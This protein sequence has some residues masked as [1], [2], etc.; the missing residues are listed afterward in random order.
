MKKI[1]G[2]I[3]AIL[4]LMLYGM[5]GAEDTDS[6]YKEIYGCGSGFVYCDDM[7]SVNQNDLSTDLAKASMVLARGT[8]S[9]ETS[10]MLQKMGYDTSDHNY[11]DDEGLMDD[12][13]AYTIGCRDVPGTNKR[14][15]CVVIR[16]THGVSEWISNFKFATNNGI[17]KG[18]S[19]AA[20]EVDK[21]LA[22]Y[23]SGRKEIIFW[24]TGHSRG[25]AVANI[26]AAKYSGQFKTF[27]YTYACP[28]V[29]T[30][31]SDSYNIWNFNNTRDL[32]PKLPH[33]R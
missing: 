10:S 17:H 12:E 8:Y 31:P 7:L 1:A 24:F 13:V 16:G 11:S 20:D 14:I 5:A 9:H 15:I 23:I 4:L 30:N 2:L 28:A 19:D 27:G 18:F 29:C 32:V 3:V 33:L 25:A 6:K 22:A 26:L 21:S